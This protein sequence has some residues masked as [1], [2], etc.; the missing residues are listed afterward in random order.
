MI[1]D[2]SRAVTEDAEKYLDPV[3]NIYLLRL[4]EVEYDRMKH[5]RADQANFRSQRD[6]LEKILATYEY[7]GVL[8]QRRVYFYAC[9]ADLLVEKLVPSDKPL[10]LK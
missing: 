10:A 2:D 6:I 8:I 1:L 4:R 9:I 3:R 5:G 7:Y